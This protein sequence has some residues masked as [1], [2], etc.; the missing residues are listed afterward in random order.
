M[1]YGQQPPYGAQPPFGQPGFGQ[2]LGGM[3]GA[4]F[5]PQSPM[6]GPM[7]GLGGSAFGAAA[8]GPSAGSLITRD[9]GLIR[10]FA[11]VTAIALATNYGLRMLQSIMQFVRLKGSYLIGHAMGELFIN[12][13][14]LGVVATFTIVLMRFGGTIADYRRSPTA[15]NLEN[16]FG[17]HNTYWKVWGITACVIGFLFLVYLAFA[18]AAP[19]LRIRR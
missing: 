19:Q 4:G 10:I 9:L 18:M 16:V 12:T 14:A 8:T 1:P 5:G 15:N 3:P 11:M 7:Q 6:Q 17:A 13:I 2:P